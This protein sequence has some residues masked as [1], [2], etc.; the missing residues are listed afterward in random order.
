MPADNPRI[1]RPPGSSRSSDSSKSFRRGCINARLAFWTLQQDALQSQWP[2]RSKTHK[3]LTAAVLP[4]G[5]LPLDAFQLGLCRGFWLNRSEMRRENGPCNLTA[6][7]VAQ[8]DSVF[9]GPNGGSVRGNRPGVPRIASPAKS[10]RADDLRRCAHWRLMTIHQAHETRI[11]S[12]ADDYSTSLAFGE[13][14]ALSC[15]PGMARC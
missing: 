15:A 14:G 11:R 10:S 1:I 12:L 6:G 3:E 8:V 2:I 7:L 9:E 4:R 13:P 5:H